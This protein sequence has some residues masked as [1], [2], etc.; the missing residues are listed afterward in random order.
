MAEAIGFAASIIAFVQLADRV[1]SLSKKFL[2]AAQDAPTTLRR[3]HAET[4]SMKDILEELKK[5]YDSSDA[6]D[7]A[8]IQKATH[9]PIET[10]QA[11]VEMLEQELA[12]LSISPSHQKT[13]L[14]K[15]QKVKQSLMWATSSEE[16][17]KKLIAAMITQKA[18][19]SLALV[20]DISYVTHDRCYYKPRLFLTDYP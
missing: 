19:L 11:S 14:S 12:K 18:T 6:S 15:R 2:D 7:S 13:G 5:M 4:S 16:R 10:C 20:A 8:A 1:I 3:V 9:K 17:T